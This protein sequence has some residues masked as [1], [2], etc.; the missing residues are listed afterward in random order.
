MK[1][2]QKLKA[3]YILAGATFV[4]MAGFRPEPKYGTALLKK[5]TH[6]L[7]DYSS[8]LTVMRQY[9]SLPTKLSMVEHTMATA[10][11]VS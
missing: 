6:H 2:S 9:H 8:V 4:K 5:T 11:I 7:V 1:S 10:K 3:G